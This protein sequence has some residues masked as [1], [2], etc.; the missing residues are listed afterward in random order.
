MNQAEQREQE[1]MGK[2][3]AAMDDSRPACR[4]DNRFIADD[5]APEAVSAICE[6]CPM[7]TACWEYASA[8]RPSGAIWAGRR[9]G[10]GRPPRTEEETA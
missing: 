10:R 2:L 6:A 8:Q 1:A 5:T 3:I 9:W 7:L 4:G